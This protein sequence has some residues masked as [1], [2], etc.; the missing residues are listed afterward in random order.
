MSGV[1]RWRL[2][3]AYDWLSISALNDA[4]LTPLTASIDVTG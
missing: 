3:G 4:W 2:C 1:K